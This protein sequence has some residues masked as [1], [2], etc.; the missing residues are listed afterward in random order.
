MSM[1]TSY[2]DKGTNVEMKSKSR[3]FMFKYET[4]GYHAVAY[5]KKC[6]RYISDISRNERDDISSS[7]SLVLNTLVI[8]IF[9]KGRSTDRCDRR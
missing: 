3:A 8:H 2:N 6:S 7:C 4:S 9:S 5:E 1:H